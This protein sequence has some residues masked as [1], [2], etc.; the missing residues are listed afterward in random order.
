MRNLL[1][2]KGCTPPWLC[3]FQVRKP[4]T[5]IEKTSG[6]EKC[7]GFCLNFFAHI[8]IL[9]L[10]CLDISYI[11][12]LI[13]AGRIPTQHPTCHSSCHPRWHCCESHSCH[14]LRIGSRNPRTIPASMLNS[15]VFTD[16]SSCI[17][18]QHF[19]ICGALH[20]QNN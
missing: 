8:S 3:R 14:A 4:S 19:C 5:L 1:S 2:Q 18:K 12:R 16:T 11:Q 6:N 20:S 17:Q 15:T 9:S 7:L 13:T 10:Q